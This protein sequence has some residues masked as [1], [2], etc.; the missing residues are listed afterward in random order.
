[1]TFE[2]IISKARDLPLAQRKALIHQ[3][4][5][6]ISPAEAMTTE[7]RI[8]GLHAGQGWVSDDFTDELSDGFWLGRDNE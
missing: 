7:K 6:S 2:E 8:A 1:M 4:V 3:L 5:E